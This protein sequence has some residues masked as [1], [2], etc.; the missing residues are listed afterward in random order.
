M[1]YINRFSQIVTRGVHPVVIIFYQSFYT[2]D[3]FG[4]P[5]PAK[6]FDQNWPGSDNT[7]GYTG[8][9]YDYYAGL[10]YARA[11]LLHAGDWEI[12]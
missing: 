6:K 12:Y 1:N 2:Y 10:N 3:E 9:Q 7:F 11:R 8:L 5:K 4:V